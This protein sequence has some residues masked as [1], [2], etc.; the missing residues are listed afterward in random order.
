MG[1]PSEH[2]LYNT[3]Y[4]ESITSYRTYLH[5]LGYHPQTCQTKYLSLQEFFH[6]ISQQGKHQLEAITHTDIDEFYN[7]L[8]TRISQ[9]TGDLLQ[10][11][12][13]YS[14]MRSVQQYFGY[15]Q[16]MH[17]VTHNPTSH[18]QLHSP[19]ETVNRYLFSE[20]EIQSLLSVC[21]TL[22][23]EA[24]LHIAYGCG[25]RVSELSNLNIKDV[26]LL[27]N[28]IIV[29]KGKNSKRRIIPIT[30]KIK[31]VVDS[32][33]SSEYD[34]SS[35]DIRLPLFL[36]SKRNRMQEWTFNSLLK[37]LI[38]RTNFGRQLSQKTLLKIGVH[39]LRHSIATHLLARGMALDQ[40][41]TFL[42]HSHI[43]TTERYTHIT[44][45]Q[46]HTLL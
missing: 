42:G 16:A 35:T 5:I 29:E 12:A 37:Q 44:Q 3:I 4:Q 9:K 41:Q 7:Y 36:N 15:A 40:I 45:R 31:T 39:S 25:L 20:Q 33:I 18:L 22:Q 28:R 14:I 38:L 19:Q 26:Q 13:V 23:E 43:E 6:W 17:K 32:F 30:A 2:Q 10:E 8:Q 24:F 1:K 21:E 11:K 34:F 27:E 46:I